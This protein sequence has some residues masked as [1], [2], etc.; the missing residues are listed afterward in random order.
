ME[1]YRAQFC[2]GCRIDYLV[3]YAAITHSSLNDQLIGLVVEYN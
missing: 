1:N 3:F 2:V